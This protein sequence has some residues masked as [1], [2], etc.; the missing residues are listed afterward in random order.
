MKWIRLLAVALGSCVLERRPD[1]ALRFALGGRPEEPI[2]LAFVA[3]ELLRVLV[4]G[5]AIVQ[6]IKI[7]VLGVGQ[8]LGHADGGVL[9]L[10]NAPEQHLFHA[11]LAVEIPLPRSVLLQ[12]DR[13]RPVLR[14]HEQLSLI[15]I[16]EP[17]RRTP[18]SY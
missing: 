18:I 14:A 2:L 15:H 16:S 10:S 9:I 12:R 7:L 1:R 3:D 11:G 4:G 5:A 17:T 8:G 13:E 6:S